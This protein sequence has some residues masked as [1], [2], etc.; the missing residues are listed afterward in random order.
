MK[1]QEPQIWYRT[2]PSVVSIEK[3]SVVYA[4]KRF[5][6]LLGEEKRQAI[7]GVWCSY[8]RSFEDAKLLIVKHAKAEKKR[9]KNKLREAEYNLKRAEA[10]SEEQVLD[11]SQGAFKL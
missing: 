6:V 2:F 10:L 3:V 4:T 1:L 5:V 7:T 8:S 11:R 9:L